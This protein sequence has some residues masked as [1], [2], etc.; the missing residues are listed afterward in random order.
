MSPFNFNRTMGSLES[1]RTF[2]HILNSNIAESKNEVV[3]SLEKELIKHLNKP[4]LYKDK[5]ISHVFSKINSVF[6]QCKVKQY[7]TKSLNS[8]LSECLYNIDKVILNN[9]KKNPYQSVSNNELDEDNIQYGLPFYYK[10]NDRNMKHFR[11]TPFSDESVNFSYA[12]I[13]S[14]SIKHYDSFTCP[15]KIFAIFGHN[16]PIDDLYQLNYMNDVMTFSDVEKTNL[17]IHKHF[18]TQNSYDRSLTDSVVEFKFPADFASPSPIAWV[19][20][21]GMKSD[22]VDK[23]TLDHKFSQRLVTRYLTFKLIRGEDLYGHTPAE[24]NID[25]CS[26]L[27]KGYR[28]NSEFYA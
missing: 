17:P 22:Q 21:S 10:P 7:W 1:L 4:D 24:V 19:S 3:Y 14:F 15:V 9:F 16:S 2:C 13:E 25:I 5:D 18:E 6:S 28:L 23:V 20:I 26:I 11:S 27:F 8:T 12:Y